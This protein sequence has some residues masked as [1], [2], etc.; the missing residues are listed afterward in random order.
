MARRFVET[1]KEAS[2]HDGRRPGGDCLGDV[3]AVADAAVGDDGNA[4]LTGGAGTF[5]YGRN[6][7]NAHAGDN[8]RCADRSGADADFDGVGA[9]G[10]KVGSAFGC[11]DVAGDD[12]DLVGG[13]D[14]L[15]SADNV[16][17]VPVGGI[18]HQ[19]I[20][21]CIDEHLGPL[22]VADAHSRS[23]PKPASDVLATLRELSQS[24]D[25]TH[26]NQPGEFAVCIY[27]QEFFHLVAVED[28]FSLIE[29]GFRRGGYEVLRGHYLADWAVLGKEL[30]VPPGQDADEFA[31]VGDDGEPRHVVIG[32][33]P[34]G[35]RGGFIRPER[36][37]IDNYAVLAAF[38]LIDLTGLCLRR[39]VLMNDPDAADLRQCDSQ[40]RFRNRVHRGRDQRDIQT[41]LPRQVC[42]CVHVAGDDVGPR[43]DQQNIIESYTVGYDLVHSDASLPEMGNRIIQADLMTIGCR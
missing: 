23:D 6:L 32:H 16:A 5:I 28:F 18:D 26:R 43:G 41:D 8:P 15:D 1:G 21:A 13:L 24:L 7:R 2:H 40:R 39:H 42:G 19:D 11:G 33:L 31:V 17:A 30:H 3:A 38:D 4:A 20:D 36:Y 14:P 27:Q 12:I 9:G 10:D 35:R 25:V 37:R 29:F 22:V 34:S